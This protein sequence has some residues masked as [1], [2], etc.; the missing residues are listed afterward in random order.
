MAFLSFFTFFSCQQWFLKILRTEYSYAIP[1][2]CVRWLF[3]NSSNMY[4]TF[5]Y[6]YEILIILNFVLGANIHFRGSLLPIDLQR[7][8]FEKTIFAH[9]WIGDNFNDFHDRRVSV[10]QLQIILS[11]PFALF[12]SKEYSLTLFQV[13]IK[14]FKMLQ[15]SIHGVSTPAFQLFSLFQRFPRPQSL[16]RKGA[17][18]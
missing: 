1:Y 8:F 3:L 6:I 9:I 7:F 15:G 10:G 2:L 16:C 14:K 4:H 5:E 11:V 13:Q 18:T 12:L 17:P